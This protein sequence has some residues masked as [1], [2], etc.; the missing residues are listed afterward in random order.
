MLAYEMEV[1][2]RGEFRLPNLR[3]TEGT[4]VTLLGRLGELEWHQTVDGLTVVLSSMDTPPGWHHH[5]GAE[6]PCD[7]AYSFKITPIPTW[8]EKNEW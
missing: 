2:H 1:M 3:V 8:F 6:I 7:H 4:T 5:T